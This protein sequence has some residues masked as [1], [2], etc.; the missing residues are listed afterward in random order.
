MAKYIVPSS[1]LFEVKEFWRGPSGLGKSLEL[2]TEFLPSPG[3]RTPPGAYRWH[4]T[5]FVPRLTGTHWSYIG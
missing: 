4:R 3:L 1:G 5:A 2:Q